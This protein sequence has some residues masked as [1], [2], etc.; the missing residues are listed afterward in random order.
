MIDVKSKP[1][2]EY[3][4]PTRYYSKK[5]ERSVAKI[6]G[7]KTIKNS[8]ATMWQKGDVQ[9]K[10]WLI[11]CKTNIKPK[12]TITFHKEWLTKTRDETLMMNKEHYAVSLS[13]GSGEENY[14]VIDENTFKLFLELLKND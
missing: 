13:F 3:D 4:K 8:G 7:G 2:T 11:E 1:I 9:T 5:Q 14:Y 12:K 10:D 6:V